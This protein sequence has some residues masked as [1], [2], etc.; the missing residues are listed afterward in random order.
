M[1]TKLP[2]VLELQQVLGDQIQFMDQAAG[3]IRASGPDVRLMIQHLRGECEA[4]VVTV[5]AEDRRS[6]EGVF[7][8]YYVLE[9]R[10]NPQYLI[11]QA[12]VSPDAPEFPS[13]SAQLPSLNWQEREIQDWFGLKAGGH[14]NPRRVALHDNWPDVHPLRKDFPIETSLPL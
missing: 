1:T 2:S 5:F 9:Q 10:G 7:F 11:V 3:W 6:A 8:N 12:P 13:L 14:P 4:R